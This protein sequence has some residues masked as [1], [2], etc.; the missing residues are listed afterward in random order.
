MIKCRRQAADPQKLKK[1]VNG[2][3]FVFCLWKR[4]RKRLKNNRFRI[5]AY[6]ALVFDA[7]YSLNLKRQL[8]CKYGSAGPCSRQRSNH[9]TLNTSTTL[10][11]PPSL[12]EARLYIVFFY[13]QISKHHTISNAMLLPVASL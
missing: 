6:N 3:F 13:F 11:T 7:R 12:H 8:Q 4:K 1:I 10:S 2:R 9:F 5:P